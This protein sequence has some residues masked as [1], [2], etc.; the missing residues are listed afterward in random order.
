MLEV[1]KWNG[2]VF[3]GCGGFVG[4]WRCISPFWLGVELVVWE[5]AGRGGDE[6]RA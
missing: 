1:Q 2:Y 4:R 3:G 6:M 5:N